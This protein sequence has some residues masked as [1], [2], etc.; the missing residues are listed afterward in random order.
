MD[1][2]LNLSI[3]IQSRNG[4]R[5]WQQVIQTITSIEELKGK[6]VAATLGTDP[7][8]FLLRSLQEVGLSSKDLEIVNLQ[9]SDGANAL[10]TGQ[11]DAWAGL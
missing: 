8:I 11:V 6:K 3:F 4:L 10:L 2:R 9:H 5:L 1:L 7:Y